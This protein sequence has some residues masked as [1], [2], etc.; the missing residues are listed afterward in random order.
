MTYLIC[1]Y[2]KRK[3]DKEI[4]NT[5]EVSINLFKEKQYWKEKCLRQSTNYL[6]LINELQD[7][8]SNYEKEEID[9]S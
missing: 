1:C 8:L 9:L 6:K 7:K 3:K 4:I 2:Y 5:S